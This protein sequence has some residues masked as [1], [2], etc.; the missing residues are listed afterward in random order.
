MEIKTWS[1]T[2]THCELLL[3]SKRLTFFFETF[4]L[5]GINYVVT[6]TRAKVIH[7]P[8]ISFQKKKEKKRKKRLHFLFRQNAIYQP[9]IFLLQPQIMKHVNI[10]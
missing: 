6:T 5:S 3:G 9:P 7:K 10:I 1:L 4:K 2:L 8:D